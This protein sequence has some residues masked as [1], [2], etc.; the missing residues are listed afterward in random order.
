MGFGIKDGQS[1]AQLSKFSDGVIVGSKLVDQCDSRNYDGNID[2]IKI[3][4]QIT[5][6]LSEMHT[7]M[8]Q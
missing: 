8:S 2:K 6:I 3:I 7:A 1:A 4:N 5:E